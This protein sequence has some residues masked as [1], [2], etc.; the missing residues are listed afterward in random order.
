MSNDYQPESAGARERAP[1]VR[2]TWENL[3]FVHWRLPAEV[4]RALVPRELEI[5]LF[6][7]SAW[8]GLVPFAM[9]RCDFAGVPRVGLPGLRDFYECN[10][11]TYVRHTGVGG[12]RS[13]VWFF[14]L[15]AQTPL[16]VLGGRWLWNLNY[17][18]SRFNVQQ[19]GSTTAYKLVRRGVPGL[20]DGIP[21]RTDVRWRTVGDVLPQSQ[22]GSI[23]HFL[24]ERYWLFTQ[25][26]WTRGAHGGGGRILAGEVRHKPWSL[27]R[28]EVLHLDDTLVAAAGV[29]GGVRIEVQGEAIAL[30]SR[31]LDVLGYGLVAC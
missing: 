9:R 3:L 28:A 27:S 22:P 30:A 15:D 20:G 19:E 31:S 16:P 29:R 21:A 1:D 17:V 13:G 7:G 23:E 2:M 25:S 10:V 18:W 5:D 8:I 14:S 6:D 4:M 24:T 11:R 12:T 26:R